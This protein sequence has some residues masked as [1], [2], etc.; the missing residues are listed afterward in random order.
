MVSDLDIGA[1]LAEIRSRAAEHTRRMAEDPEYR[2]EHERQIAEMEA[3]EREERARVERAYSLAAREERRVARQIPARLWAHL[4]APQE[5]APLAAVRDFMRPE[6]PRTFLVLA[7]GVGVGKTLAAAWGLDIEFAVRRRLKAEEMRIRGEDPDGTGYVVR[8]VGGLFLSA[9]S[10][11]RAGTFNDEFWA[12]ARE[13][14]RLVIDDLGTEPRD[15]KGWAAANLADLLN[16]RY[17]WKLKTVLTTNL[18]FERFKA[19]YVDL[20]LGDRL[21]ECGT[22]FE[23]AGDS[24]RRPVL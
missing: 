21:R 16:H 2:A 17:D 22:F 14:A 11:V 9:M 24:L 12:D 19:A 4:D 6:D 18:D 7:G 13:T 1:K 15:D 20:R 3:K 5:T 10:L 8:Q 23:C